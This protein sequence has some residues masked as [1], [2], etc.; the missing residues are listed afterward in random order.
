M[1]IKLL[2]KKELSEM[3]NVS[4]RFIE[5][6]TQSRRIRGQIKVGRLWRYSKMEIEKALLN[7]KDFLLPRR[8]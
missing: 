6:H 4:E 8:K 7:G 2:D 5:K 3:L 1:D